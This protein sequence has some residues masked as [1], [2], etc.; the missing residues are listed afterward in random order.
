MERLN[1]VFGPKVRHTLL[2]FI[3]LKLIKRMHVYFRIVIIN[4]LHKLSFVLQRVQMNARLFILSIFLR[5]R[6][7]A[8]CVVCA[9][10][11]D[12]LFRREGG[13]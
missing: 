8:D 1:N 13:R 9:W 5:F 6:A 3:L 4:H 7:A 10:F 12:V 2:S 11:E